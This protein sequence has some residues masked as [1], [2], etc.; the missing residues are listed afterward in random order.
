MSSLWFYTH[1][2]YV[3]NCNISQQSYI[4]YYFLNFDVKTVN[5]NR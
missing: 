4:N 2:L 3:T 1:K 5:C